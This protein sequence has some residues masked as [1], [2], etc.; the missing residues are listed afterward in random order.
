MTEDVLGLPG[1]LQLAPHEHR[2]QNG[3][4]GTLTV[5][6]TTHRLVISEGGRGDR[7]RIVPL[8]AI[9]TMD[10]IRVRRRSHY[11]WAAVFVAVPLATTIAS[12][13]AQQSAGR[14][15]GVSVTVVGYLWVFGV[16]AAAIALATLRGP[17]SAVVR[18]LGGQV[19]WTHTVPGRHQAQAAR[20]AADVSDAMV[21]LSATPVQGRSG[22]R[23]EE[24]Q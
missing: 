8:S 11:G 1:G 13:A 5:W 17:W 10:V 24:P 7:F 21:R 12:A 9:G 23:V 16:I 19:L 20:L 18:G 6:L 4:I 15:I 22:E 2:L 14:S 3:A